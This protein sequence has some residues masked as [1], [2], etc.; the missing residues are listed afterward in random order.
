LRK[1]LVKKGQDFL[2]KLCQL[3]RSRGGTCLAESWAGWRSQ[4]LFRCGKCGREWNSLPQN[5][6][7]RGANCKS[8]VL[9]ERHARNRKKNDYFKKIQKLG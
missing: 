9:R 3:A 1:R 2:L 8:C 6:I 5:I 4:Y 7:N